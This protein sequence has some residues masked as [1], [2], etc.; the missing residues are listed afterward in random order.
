MADKLNSTESG[1]PTRLKRTIMT[2]GG[3]LAVLGLPAALNFF[4]IVPIIILSDGSDTP[5]YVLTSLLLA[6]ITFG[7]GGVAFWHANQSLKGKPSRPLKLPSL[8]LFLESLA[9]CLL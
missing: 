3:I 8:L 9:C 5:T 6:V 4:C 2:A 7:A 1:I